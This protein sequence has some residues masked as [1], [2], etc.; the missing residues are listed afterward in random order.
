[1]SGSIPEIPPSS[2]RLLDLSR[3]ISRVGRDAFTGVD[4]VEAAYLRALLADSKPLFS[5]VRTGFGFTL[6]D[7]NGTQALADRLLAKTP[8]G[9]P[10]FLSR[11]FLKASDERRGAESDLRR[12]SIARAGRGSLR[13]ILRRFLPANTV[14]INVG[15]SNLRSTMFDAVHGLA[16]GRA[17]ILVHDTIPLDFPEYQREGTVERFAARMEQVARKADLVIYN[18]DATCA[19]ATP[20]FE[21]IG[22]VPSGITAHLGIETPVPEAASIPDSI[23]R[24]RPYFVILG[25]IEPRKNHALLLDLWEKMARE[26][27]VDA[28][29]RLFIIGARGWENAEVFARLDDLGPLRGVVCELGALP[30][31]AAHALIEGSAGLLMPS[32]S[33]GFGLPPGE[34]LALGAPVIASNLPVYWEVFGNNLVYPEKDDLLSWEKAVDTVLENRTNTAGEKSSLPTWNDHFN[35][36]LKVI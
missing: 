29:P 3:L 36:V 13:F 1:M 8:W 12:L 17:A 14:W 20:H 21:K 34:A 33:E 25:T 10:D 18:S 9:P 7:R 11:L 6:F 4:R 23:P 26:T 27:S 15:H 22:R 19:Q 5:I 35:L 2:A 24:D 30:D 32:H 16:G 28:L 31:G